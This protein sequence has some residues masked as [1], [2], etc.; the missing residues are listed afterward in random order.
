MNLKILFRQVNVNK[1]LINNKNQRKCIIYFR[2]TKVK[3][4]EKTSIVN[5]PRIVPNVVEKAHEENST[6]RRVEEKASGVPD[7]T[8]GQRLTGGLY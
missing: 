7:W 6:A 4:C 1:N 3:I 5:Q 2:D 8:G